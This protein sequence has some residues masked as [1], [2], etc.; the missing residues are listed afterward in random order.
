MARPAVSNR[1]PSSKAN[2][3]VESFPHVI[4][5]QE[6]NVFPYINKGDFKKNQI[7]IRGL[8]QETSQMT[9]RNFYSQFGQVLDCKI[10]RDEGNV[11]RGY[12]FVSFKSGEAVDLALNSLPHRID[13]KEI[14][15]V[16]RAHLNKR[17]LTLRVMDLPPET[18]EE[19]LREFYSKFGRITRCNLIRNLDSGQM[20]YGVVAFSTQEDLDHALEAEPHIIDGTEVFL[21]Y[22][23]SELDLR[24]KVVPEG[25]TRE[26][27]E[28]SF[29]Q[30]GELRDCRFEK[31][32]KGHNSGED[33]E[34][35]TNEPIDDYFANEP[36]R[37][38]PSQPMD[39]IGGRPYQNDR[40]IAANTF[41]SSQ[42]AGMRSV[43]SSSSSSESLSISPDESPHIDAARKT[44]MFGVASPNQTMNCK[45]HLSQISHLEATIKKLQEENEM[46]RANHPGYPSSKD[47]QSQ[48]DHNVKMRHQQN[49]P[50][51]VSAANGQPL[52]RIN[53]SSGQPP[54]HQQME[55]RRAMR[56]VSHHQALP[57]GLSPHHHHMSASP[58]S[59]PA[60]PHLGG[61]TIQLKSDLDTCRAQLQKAQ[62]DMRD[63]L[64]KADEEYYELNDHVDNLEK[65]LDEKKKEILRL[66]KLS[67]KTKTELDT[68]QADLE[69]ARE[70]K[71]RLKAELTTANE[72]IRISVEESANLGLKLKVHE[73][74]C[75]EYL[76][77][78]DKL[79]QDSGYPSS[80]DQQ[81]Q[82]DHNVKMRHQQNDPRIVSAANGQPLTR[83]NS[84]SGQPPSHQQM[85]A[86]RAMQPVS[87]HQALPRGLS[88]H[89]H[90]M[91]ASPQSHPAAPHLAEKAELDTCKADL[92][93]ARDA[94]SL[95]TEERDR[96]K[97]ELESASA[98]LDEAKRVSELTQ[99]LDEA[100]SF[101]EK[102]QSQISELS[103]KNKELKAENEIL[104]GYLEIS[105]KTVKRQRAH[106]DE[107]IEKLKTKPPMQFG[108]PKP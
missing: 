47:Q 104:E 1:V 21:S 17:E 53:S 87:H 71:N 38:E 67:N 54:S 69:K 65:E 52:T 7:M 93:K 99:Q 91:S 68:C 30:Y 58:Q 13:D 80:K 14:S 8:P 29:S 100:K 92:E 81:S 45:T 39:F 107:Q 24:V 61:D 64:K 37:M 16:Q 41:I 4:D 15:N 36:V 60:A 74:K 46:L 56:P 18:T 97:T 72:T 55:A 75:K 89:H 32:P 94:I 83:I 48:R 43:D 84:S 23:T 26:S 101:S 19:S 12:A 73:D 10:I 85:E 96:L 34:R 25:V 103:E 5:G 22:L 11:S 88:P 31:S 86:R 3:A 108:K 57:R 9:L 44:M 51:I 40:P 62:D 76:A 63:R 28:K 95:V 42:G 2:R 20:K 70:D 59:H 33:Q 27:F 35:Q 78:I 79:K 77:E 50:R 66:Q 98:K 49:D 6:V 82:R 90:H 106:I 102:L 105:E